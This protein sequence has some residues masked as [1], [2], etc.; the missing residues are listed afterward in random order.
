MHEIKI[1]ELVLK[2]GCDVFIKHFYDVSADFFLLLLIHEEG[3]VPFK[4]AFFEEGTTFKDYTINLNSD[5]TRVLYSKNFEFE[6]NEK[7]IELSLVLLE[8]YKQL[9]LSRAKIKKL[10]YQN[11]SINTKNRGIL[12]HQIFKA[13]IPINMLQQENTIKFDNSIIN[14]HFSL[15]K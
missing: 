12:F 1:K 9:V 5:N 10:V 2:K 13:T 8:N 11:E 7:S 15:K 4:L 14:I 3:E 6:L